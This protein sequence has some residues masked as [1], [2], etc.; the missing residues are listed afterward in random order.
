LSIN[1]RLSQLQQLEL[2]LH[3]WL[4]ACKIQVITQGIYFG[5]LRELDIQLWYQG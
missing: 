2:K 3:K 4:F 5:F 1:H